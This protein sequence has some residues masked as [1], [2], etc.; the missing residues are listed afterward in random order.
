MKNEELRIKNG[1]FPLGIKND[2]P[3]LEG[4]PKGGVVPIGNRFF[5]T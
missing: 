4:C 5:T 2:S 1:F 3:P